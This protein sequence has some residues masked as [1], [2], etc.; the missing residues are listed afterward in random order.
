LRKEVFFFFNIVSESTLHF[1]NSFSLPCLD[2][3]LP[4]IFDIIRFHFFFISIT[5][6]ILIVSNTFICFVAYRF[7]KPK[8]SPFTISEL[9]F[10][11]SQLFLFKISIWSSWFRGLTRIRNRKLCYFFF[12]W[13]ILLLWLGCQQILSVLYLRDSS[14]RIRRLDCKHRTSYPRI[15]SSIFFLFHLSL[16]VINGFYVC[17][18][19]TIQLILLFENL[20]F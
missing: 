15:L 9:N 17:S 19:Q 13:I 14:K 2:T 20:W 11:L 10:F 8:K 5:V 6:V 1:V 18:L 12:Y 3:Q 7:C 16:F 4:V